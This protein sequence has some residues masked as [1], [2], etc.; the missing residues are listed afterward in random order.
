[1]IMKE[2]IDALASKEPTP[3]GGG[4]AALVG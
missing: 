4:A 1:M 2:F 3:G